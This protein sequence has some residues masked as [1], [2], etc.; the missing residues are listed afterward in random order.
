MGIG[1]GLASAGWS[2]CGCAIVILNDLWIREIPS[3]F[4]RIKEKMVKKLVKT[5]FDG[6]K[7]LIL[8]KV[9]AKMIFALKPDVFDGILIGSI[10]GKGDQD[11]RPVFF[12]DAII[13]LS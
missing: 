6:G 5:V 10:G 1:K 8:E 11:Q 2:A 7:G 13:Q 3:E 12:W 9:F 4:G